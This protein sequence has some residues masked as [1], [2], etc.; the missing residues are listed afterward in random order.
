M[1]RGGGG[2]KKGGKKRKKKVR[3]H[4]A[5]IGQQ[6]LR[7]DRAAMYFAL[8]CVQDSLAH[9]YLILSSDLTHA[10]HY[11]L[12]PHARSSPPPPFVV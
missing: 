11:L 6:A 2:K 12:H 7:H 8:G 4:V 5:V 9:P 3:G 10:L 1:I